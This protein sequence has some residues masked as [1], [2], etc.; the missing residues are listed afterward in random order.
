MPAFR[1][2]GDL[3]VAAA[4]RE[5]AA[6]LAAG[7]AAVVDTGGAEL[8][9]GRD[10]DPIYWTSSEESSSTPGESSSDDCE[11]S[12]KSTVGCRLVLCGGG[13]LA[14]CCEIGGLG[15]CCC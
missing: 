3:G 1:G 6:T 13:H 7:E 2:S 4:L 14:V 11:V 8:R 15:R 5:E 9:D 10:T 12:S